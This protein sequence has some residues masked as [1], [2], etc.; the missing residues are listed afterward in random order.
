MDCSARPS[1]ADAAAAEEKGNYREALRL[2]NELSKNDKANAKL[3]R[4]IQ[5][6]IE[7]MYGVEGSDE[8]ISIWKHAPLQSNEKPPLLVFRAT[9]ELNRC[10]YVHG[11]TDM[12]DLYKTPSSDDVWEYNIE[13]RTWRCLVTSGK[14]PGARSGHTMFPHKKGNNSYLFMWGGMIVGD[15][16]NSEGIC[17]ADTKLYRLDL[18]TLKWDI[19]KTKTQPPGKREEHA[20]VLYK[21]KYYIHGGSASNGDTFKDTWVLNLSN[22]RWSPL[23][24]YGVARHHHKMFACRNKLYVLGGRIREPAVENP[25]TN[26]YNKKYDNPSIEEFVSFDLVSRTWSKEDILGSDR[27]HDISE[28]TMLP[29]YENDGDAD[30][31]SVIVW[32]GY[33]EM[34]TGI[35]PTREFMEG[36]YGED[37][38]SDFSLP[39]RK[40]LLRFDVSTNVWK[41]LKPTFDILPKAESIACVDKVQRGVAHL[42]IGSGYGVD[43][44][45]NSRA[46]SFP[47]DMEEMLSAT[48]SILSGASM[49]SMGHSPSTTNKFFSVMISDSFGEASSGWAWDFYNLSDSALPK[50]DHGGLN[51]WSPI[52]HTLTGDLTHEDFLRPPREQIVPNDS[53]MI[54]VRVVLHGLSK[55]EMNGKI[56]R[57]GKWLSKIKRYQVYLST[58]ESSI[59]SS[60]SIKIENL[61]IAPP[62]SRKDIDDAI[63][64]KPRKFPTVLLVV[65]I[66]AKDRNHS[67]P[68]WDEM[69]DPTSGDWLLPS[70]DSYYGPVSRKAQIILRLMAEEEAGVEKWRSMAVLAPNQTL[71]C[72]V[73][74]SHRDEEKLKR[75]MGNDT[76]RIPKMI[77]SSRLF[78][79]FVRELIDRDKPRVDEF[80]RRVARITDDVVEATCPAHLKLA[81]KLDGL[82][83][84]FSRQLI[85]SS[86]LTIRELHDQVLAPVMNWQSNYHSYA[87]RVIPRP[88]VSSDEEALEMIGQSVWMGPKTSTS[89]DSV[90]MPLYIGGCLA[91]DKDITIGQL[92]AKQNMDKES[93]GG[94]VLYMQY[95][96]DFGDWYSHTLM[97]ECPR[98][99]DIPQDSS[100]AHL[101]SGSGLEVPEDCSGIV[102]YCKLM[103]EFTGRLGVPGELGDNNSKPKPSHPGE[104][105]W[106]KLF[107]SEVRAKHNM[108][109]ERG[110]RCNPLVFDIEQT[111][112]NLEVALRRPTQKAG[113]ENLN[114]KTHDHRTGLYFDKQRKASKPEPKNAT[115]FCAVCGITVS[116]KL[117]S[118]CSSVAYCCR[119]H[120]VK[121]WPNHK[122]D[123]KRLKKE[124]KTKK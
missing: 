12:A 102:Q 33:A 114:V 45:T 64:S 96:H 121:H 88:D 84:P 74:P 16:V 24:D 70:F 51:P 17:M 122:A 78:I 2:Y 83:P 26:P 69:F 40:R 29:I 100:V 9:C 13:T 108:Q 103:K 75:M 10:I 89:L 80:E 63:T 110:L 123:C 106:W 115:K 107:Q 34:P 19:V 43:P 105:R 44:K 67:R 111:R 77:K 25:V 72:A 76:K 6:V 21:D 27:P 35:V 95:V 31:K 112:K 118:L 99:E 46:T 8:T 87:L 57:C 65:M 52:L 93:S 38:S 49:Q 66:T 39:Y 23:K 28:F 90:Y 1:L 14:K 36:R 7:I 53:Q 104:E 117:C 101:I 124:S 54:G 91:N 120:Q 4:N 47:E 5:R 81:V 22:F 94:G 37:F 97:F 15:E 32:G 113:K 50:L 48:G 71:H 119:D 20:G 56:G 60:I 82:K 58:N 59:T 98:E 92:F 85:V 68:V 73:W 11:G 79:D 116:L 41:E 42:L 62:A 30:P 86:E 55:R 109:K 3:K 61:R 18:S